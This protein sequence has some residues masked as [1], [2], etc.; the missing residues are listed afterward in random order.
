MRDRGI[1]VCCHARDFRCRPA[2]RGVRPDR[3]RRRL[4]PVRH[5][6][7]VR[8]VER[9]PTR[10][11]SPLCTPLRGA[12]TSL[13]AGLT[14]DSARKAVRHLRDAA[15]RTAPSRSPD[16]ERLLVWDGRRLA[17]PT[18]R[19]EHAGP[20]AAAGRPRVIV[21]DLDPCGDPRCQVRVA[22]VAPLSSTGGW[23]A[24][25][26]SYGDRWRGARCGPSG[27]SPAGSPASWS[28]P[29]STPPGA[30]DGGRDAG[31]ARAD[32]P[33]LRLQLPDHDRL[34]RAHRS[35]A[36]PGAACSTSPTSPATPSATRATSPPWPRSSA[37]ID[38]YLLLERAA[39]A[40]RLRFSV[41]VA[42]GGAAG[43][44]CRSCRC[45]RWW[46]TPSATAWSAAAAVHVRIVARDAG[47]E[48]AIS[49]EDDGVGMDP[50]RA[51]RCSAGDPAAARRR[52]HRAGQRGRPAAPGL[53]R[54]VRPGRRDRARGGHQG[55]PAGAQVPPGAVP[56]VRVELLLREIAMWHTVEE[57]QGESP[58]MLR[59][60]AVDDEAPALEELAYLLRQDPR[61][62][63]VRTGGRAARGAA[64]P[65]TDDRDRR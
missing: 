12:S 11:R 64:R 47:A 13:R 30:A 43:R 10:P 23:R 42:P 52:R 31:A 56:W 41:E 17:H 7:A 60:L 6:A 50:E 22:M 37:A 1:T 16:T 46:R 49:V 53:R 62:E 32:L 40:T 27:R 58:A 55:E 65:R 29:S 14:A 57:Y 59:V 2:R 38:R 25:S 51:R 39:S 34:V 63:L 28:W 24:R 33:A 5:A 8:A 45:S 19:S 26:P 36:R 48:A 9:W 35:R 54:G 4:V 44:R 61:V 3:G 21:R 15:R 18:R 20:V